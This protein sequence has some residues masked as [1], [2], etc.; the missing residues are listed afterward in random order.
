M[1]AALK[2]Y[3]LSEALYGDARTL[4]QAGRVATALG[5]AVMSL[6]ADAKAAQFV[7]EVTRIG[8]RGTGPRHQERIGQALASLRLIFGDGLQ[9]IAGNTDIE[10]LSVRE[11][12]DLRQRAFYVDLNDGRISSPEDIDPNIAA[13]VLALAGN[14]V[15]GRAPLLQLDADLLAPFFVDYGAAYRQYVEPVEDQTNSPA[16]FAATAQFFAHLNEAWVFDWE[17]PYGLKTL[18]RTDDTGARS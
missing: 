12:W 14:A 1:H 6:E 13:S 5:L 18:R 17:P 15:A 9:D 2:S 8:N 16:W 11:I 4:W 3:R 10:A 7:A